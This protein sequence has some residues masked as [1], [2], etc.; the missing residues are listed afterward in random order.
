[1]SAVSIDF[2]QSIGN[3][4]ALFRLVIGEVDFLLIEI[5]GLVAVGLPVHDRK[6]E[7]R[8]HKAS[9]FF[10]DRGCGTAPV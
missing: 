7:E 1:M 9:F 4:T 8:G 5:S 6:H 3:K 10:M 2:Y